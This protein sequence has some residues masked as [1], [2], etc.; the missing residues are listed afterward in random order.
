MISLIRAADAPAWR[1]IP[2]VAVE[3]HLV[4]HIVGKDAAF[5]PLPETTRPPNLEYPTG[6][7]GLVLETNWATGGALGDGM[8]VPFDGLP[9][10]LRNRVLSYFGPGEEAVARL[11]AG[12]LV[13]LQA[14]CLPHLFCYDG[15]TA[16]LPSAPWSGGGLSL[17]VRSSETLVQL[18]EGLMPAQLVPLRERAKWGQVV[19]RYSAPEAGA[20]DTSYMSLGSMFDSAREA[21]DPEVIP[22]ALIGEWKVAV[23]GPERLTTSR[24]LG[25]VAAGLHLEQRNLREIIHLAPDYT[26]G[27]FWPALRLA[28]GGLAFLQAERC[29]FDA[30]RFFWAQKVP[31]EEATEYERE[32]GWR[33]Y[34]EGRSEDSLPAGAPPFRRLADPHLQWVPGFELVMRGWSARASGTEQGS[35]QKV[36]SWAYS[37][38]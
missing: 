7:Q 22:S 24:L 3:C 25:L 5:G 38:E 19:V 15:E 34:E 29:K 6:I 35:Y 23:F 8:A 27:P 32:I 21:G 28:F 9:E 2:A 11:P 30:G 37:I 18:A 33:R 31:P 1:V 4:P 10:E 12:D 20:Q 17:M 26:S 16:I 14:R 36:E 13:T